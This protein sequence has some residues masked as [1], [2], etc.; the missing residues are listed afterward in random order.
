MSSPI[1]NIYHNP[2][3]LTLGCCV[4]SRKCKHRVDG[5]VEP[6]NIKRLKHDLTSVLATLRC[7][8]RAFSQKKV[9]ILRIATQVIEYTLLPVSL[10]SIPIVHLT[11]F[12]RIAKIVYTAG[13]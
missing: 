8:E 5:D 1:S 3:H 9:M 4:P 6:R 2:C 11:M 13:S 10:H 7:S 12:Y